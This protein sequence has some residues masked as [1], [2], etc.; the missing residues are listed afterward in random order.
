MKIFLAFFS[1]KIVQVWI[2]SLIA[3]VNTILYTN[4]Y[5]VVYLCEVLFYKRFVFIK[6]RTEWLWEY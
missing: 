1:K 6:C 5:R 3:F 4:V 2:W